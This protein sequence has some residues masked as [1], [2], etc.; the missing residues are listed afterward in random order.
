SVWQGLRTT[1]ALLAGRRTLTDEDWGQMLALAV[2]AVDGAGCGTLDIREG[3]GFRVV[4]AHG[5]GAALLG[6]T[7]GEEAQQ[8]WYG[9]SLAAWRAGEPRV[10]SGEALAR[11]YAESD[12]ELA[13][14]EARL[15]SDVGR[16]QEVRASLCLPV[17]LE[18]EVVAHL[19]LDALS[20]AEDFGPRAAEDAA[21]FA[22]QIAALLHL[23]ERWN[24]LTRLVELH[25][26]LGAAPS[27]TPLEDH[28]TCAAQDLLRA[29]HALL[30]RHD[31]ATDT[32]RSTGPERHVPPL[33]PV[34][35]GRGAG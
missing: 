24:E 28:L 33:G 20:P 5:Y 11:A 4:A 12:A 1:V 32:L 16:R 13:S 9:A 31:E 2:A 7:L 14:P 21:L 25:S 30:L 10:V 17:V 19:N 34:V 23:Q 15:L 27:G 3:R 18:G 35:L 29:R 8:R 26:S 6:L 22:Q